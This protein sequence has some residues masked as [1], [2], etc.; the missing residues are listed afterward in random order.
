M[1]VREKRPHGTW[2]KTLF[3]TSLLALATAVAGMAAAQGRGLRGA[4]PDPA[5]QV[6]RLAEHLGLSD[7]QQQ[8]VQA[9]LEEQ[10]VEQEQVREQ[11]G[12]D[13][14]AARSEMEALREETDARLLEVLT[15][16][17]AETFQETRDRRPPPPRGG[18]RE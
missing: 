12:E 18:R 6:E 8:E 2:C 7:E 3:I 5:E 15:D 11:Y 10:S 1:D 17:Q 14:E 9:I 4:P 13:R 16:E